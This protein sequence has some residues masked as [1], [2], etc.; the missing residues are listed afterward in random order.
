MRGDEEEDAA[1]D[2]ADAKTRM[3]SSATF[4]NFSA[5]SGK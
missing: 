3:R 5:S 1:D 2:A 4:M